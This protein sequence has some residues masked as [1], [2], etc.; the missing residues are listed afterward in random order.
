MFNAAA[1][2]VFSTDAWPAKVVSFMTSP[3]RHRPLV[4][5]LYLNAALLL[6]IL[7]AMISRGGGG[8]SAFAAA[9]ISPEPIA[10]GGS[11][12]LMPAQ[13]SINTWGCYIMDIDTQTLCAY[14]FYPGEKQLRFVASRNFHWD[15]RLGNFNTTPPWPE[16]QKLGDIEAQ[17]VRA[18]EDKPAAPSPEVPNNQ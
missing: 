1:V 16:I 18:N 11:M 7:V 4:I 15:R 6:A 10:G 2:R 17:G 5:G 9:P 12:Y 3:S 8:P 14:Q 13:F